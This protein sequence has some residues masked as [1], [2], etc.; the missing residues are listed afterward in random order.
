MTKKEKIK[1]LLCYPEWDAIK[2]Q[3]I[4]FDE[5]DN[6]FNK[7]CEKYSELVDAKDLVENFQNI[8]FLM[9]TPDGYS[10]VKDFWIKKP[11]DIFEVTADNNTVKVS[12]NH[13]FEI[14]DN[15]FKKL[16]DLSVND[17]ILTKSGFKPIKKIEFLENDT[18]YDWEIISTNNRYWCDNMS[19]HNCGKTFFMLNIA[20]EAQKMGYYVIYYDS[21]GAID[22]E[23]VTS[24]EVDPTKFDHQPVSDL[25]KFRT[26]ITTLIKKLVE[27]K[28]KGFE[29]PK[30][31]IF[32]DSLGMLA[33]TK[34]IDDAISGNTAADMTRAKM[35]RSLFRII[36]ADLAGL[37][38]PLIFSNHTY[39]CLPGGYSIYVEDGVKNIEDIKPGDKVK[40]LVGY[41][42][43]EDIFT[44]ENA[45][46]L[47]IELENGEILK[48]TPNHK[49]LVN[50]DWT[51]DSSW[52]K[53]M[54]LKEG[55]FILKNT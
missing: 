11:I 4:P 36:T 41:Q 23:T 16:K 31:A 14:N 37:S 10:K 29:I 34:E 21:E 54:D 18:V 45:E 28:E 49:F 35:I 47:E 9:D 8:N 33:T 26:S 24:F 22:A 17:L 51:Q 50:E 15:Q 53:A 44:Y 5:F 20:R 1:E 13:K 25:A 32:L 40:T 27:A 39:A 3:E 48:C 30:L 52:V 12:E 43:V 42:P 38:I 19:S 2:I 55:D 6:V 7:H 46:L